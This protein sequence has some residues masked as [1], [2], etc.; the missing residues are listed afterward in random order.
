MPCCINTVH[1]TCFFL[2]PH[3]WTKVCTG[4]Q[5]D[6]SKQTPYLIV[7][8]EVVATFNYGASKQAV[9]Q[10]LLPISSRYLLRLQSLTCSTW[11]FQLMTYL[12]PPVDFH[13]HIL[14]LCMR[15]CPTLCTSRCPYR[16]L[17]AAISAGV[18]TGSVTGP[19]VSLAP[20]TGSSA[21]ANKGIHHDGQEPWQESL[22][23]S[24]VPQIW[25]YHLITLL[26]LLIALSR[27]R[28]V[29]RRD[30]FSLP[31]PRPLPWQLLVSSKHQLPGRSSKMRFNFICTDADSFFFLP[32]C[33]GSESWSGKIHKWENIWLLRS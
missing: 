6:T 28:L 7:S 13:V 24:I 15:P 23:H 26:C 17:S 16:G 3:D 33:S 32:P 4:D 22:H 8:S 29:K 9:V 27:C 5:C 1:G 25:T 2:P 14:A 18:S 10:S 19:A 12:H 21:A 20:V 30:L 31:G 11:H